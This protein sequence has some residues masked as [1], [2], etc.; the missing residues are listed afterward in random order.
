MQMNELVNSLAVLGKP[1]TITRSKLGAIT[2]VYTDQ[3]LCDLPA[4]KELVQSIGE[5]LALINTTKNVDF[6]FLISFDDKT[7]HDG[8]LKDLQNASSVPIG[9]KTDR[10]V[11]RWSVE[12]LIDGQSNEL[13][14][15]V[16]ISNPINP[17]VFLQAALSKSPGDIDNFEFEMG[18]TCVTVDGADQGY[19]DEIF[20]KVENWIKARNKPHA[21]LN[22]HDFYIRKEWY[23]DQLNYS[24]LPFLAISLASTYFY[25]QYPV[26]FLPAVPP[27]I[28]AFFVL[29][30][31]GSKLNQKMSAWARRA[32]HI[33]LFQ[34]TNGDIDYVTKLD[35]TSKNSF[36]KLFFSGLI[37]ITLNVVAAVF[38]Y[39]VLGI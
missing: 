5:K 17:L 28:A 30:T 3:Y 24:L 12:H 37:S 7:H 1:Y 38:C 39:K 13:S 36:I 35:A 32:K 14:V 18:S 15:T 10:V 6:S 23:V 2:K 25:S 16:R 27:L 20:L 8:V 4:V 11:M 34:I 21:F 26:N 31:L 22:I 9:K 29:R 33:S 19:S